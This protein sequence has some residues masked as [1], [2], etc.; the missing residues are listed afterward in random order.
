MGE[1]LTR[2]FPGVRKIAIRDW[3]EGSADKG[4]V[5][6]SLRPELN[7]RSL[8]FQKL[9]VEAGIC[10][11]CTPTSKRVAETEERPRSSW[12]KQAGVHSC[13]NKVKGEHPLP[14]AVLGTPRA[15]S[16][17]HAAVLTHPCAQNKQ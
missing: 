15:D 11:A 12:P 6:A 13:P 2:L 5:W 8:P 7:G 4:P 17:V 1:F 3:G 9:S 14:S 16:G 10:S